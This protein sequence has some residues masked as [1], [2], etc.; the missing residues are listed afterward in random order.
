MRINTLKSLKLA[1][2]LSMSMAFA[3]TLCAVKAGATTTGV[4]EVC[5][6]SDTTNPVTGSFSFTVSGVTGSFTAPVGACTGPITVPSGQVIVTE[7]AVTGIGVTKIAASGLN[8]STGATENRLVRSDLGARTAVATVVAGDIN[9]E[10][11]VTYTNAK[12]PTGFLEICKDA[13]PGSTFPA[14]TVFDFTVSGVPETITAAVGACSGPIQVPVGSVTI[15]EA[16]RAGS[17]LASVTT[18]PVGRLVS[19]NLPGGSAVVTVVAGDLST[20][21][22]ARFANQNATGQLKICKVAGSG[23]SLGTNFVISANGVPYKVPAGSATQG[24]DCVVDGTFPVGTQVIVKETIPSGGV[25]SAITAAP[26]GRLVTSNLATGTATVMIG[27]GFT[28]ITFTNTTP[29]VVTGQLKICKVAGY[30]VAVGTLFT[31]TATGPSGSAN[32]TIPAGPASQGGNCVLDGTFP[33]STAVTVREMIPSNTSLASI[34]VAPSNRAGATNLTAGTQ[35]VNIGTGFTEVTFTNKKR[36]VTKQGCSPGFFKNHTGAWVG[37]SPNQ[38]VGTVFSSV[39]PSLSG[40]TLLAALQGGG[41]P[42]LEG[43]ETILL[44][45]A[46]AALLNASNPKVGY[47]LTSAQVIAQ[48]NAAIATRDRQMILDLASTLDELNNNVGGCPLH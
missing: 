9:A 2:C 35:V 43:A 33:V 14:G 46:V 7:T 16:P 47:A 15:T 13:A 48:V 41:G 10:T 20:Q 28:E 21:T 29:P 5:K 25:I 3:G 34:T 24:G 6:S 30:G 17:T 36:Q 23:V 32:Y 18:L 19:T 22:V 42:G 39:L 40:E 12:T 8:L 26:T 37:Y 44:R 4:I 38:T 27:T 31:F 1:V 11:I 45:A